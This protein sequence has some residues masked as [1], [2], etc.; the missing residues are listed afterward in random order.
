M[1]KGWIGVDMDRTLAHHAEGTGA[2][3]PGCQ[4]CLSPHE[5]QHVEGCRLRA[6]DAGHRHVVDFLGRAVYVGDNV[7]AVARG[8]ACGQPGGPKNP[9][10]VRA[11]VLVKGKVLAI[12]D[13]QVRLDIGTAKPHMA[14]DHELVKIKP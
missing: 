6:R 7:V 14:R 8:P 3:V 5:W 11:T 1:S 9:W 2:P 13:K 4:G 12:T 10:N